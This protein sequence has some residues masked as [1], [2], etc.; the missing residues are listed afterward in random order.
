VLGAAPQKPRSNRPIHFWTLRDLGGFSEWDPDSDPVRFTSGIGH[1]IIELASRLRARG[2]PLTIGAHIPRQAATVVVH[3]EELSRYW[4]LRYRAA[5]MLRLSVAVPPHAELIV[6]RGD[7]PLQIDRPTFAG[8]EVMPNQ[9]SVSSPRQIWLPMLPQRGLIPRDPARAQRLERV[10]LKCYPENRPEFVSDPS[11]LDRIEELE[12]ELVVEDR[13]EQWH[14]FSQVDVV[15]CTRRFHHPLDA[16][17]YLRKPATK[18]IN[19]WAAGV[20]P[21]VTPDPAYLELT[22]SET[23]AMIAQ[24]PE[25][26]LSCL[27]RLRSQPSLRTAIHAGALLRGT[28]FSTES[29]LNR[30]ESLV[31][32]EYPAAGRVAPAVSA[33][34]AAF[35]L[36][37]EQIRR[38]RER[39]RSSASAMGGVES[40]TPRRP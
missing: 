25:G 36:A 12:L 19:A 3:L 37:V 11:F 22:H 34:R 35:A 31:G 17:N 40:A 8:C 9:T 28:E 29:I 23:D 26:I 38:R 4:E 10:A 33:V 5:P 1:G 15:L 32:A 14:D 39:A 13:P 6:I 30:W 24:S 21:I 18:L 20:I 27:R 16:E 7:T 2:L